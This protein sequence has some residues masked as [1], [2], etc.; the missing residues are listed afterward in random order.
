MAPHGAK[1]PYDTTSKAL[2]DKRENSD[3]F[4]LLNGD[5]KFTYHE[6][7]AYVPDG[8]YKVA[9]DDESWDTIPVPSCW[10]MHGY[11]R[12]V[13]TNV[14]YQIPV[15]APNVPSEN[16]VGCYRRTFAVDAGWKTRRTVLHF[17]GVSTAFTVYIN[18]EEVG[19]SEGTH[20]PSEFDITDYLVDGDNVMAVEVYK[21]ASSTYLED[22]D[23]WR[24]HGIF[25]E[26][27]LYS[28]AKSYISD[29]K[30]DGQ[31]VNDFVDGQVT[32]DTKIVNTNNE[33]LTV[34]YTLYDADQKV[35]G[36]VTGTTEGD[37]L[38]VKM[39][40][41]KANPWTAETPYL[42]QVVF[43]MTDAAGQV[44]DI[45]ARKFG[46]ITVE[47]TKTQLL[48][49]GVSVILKGVNRHDTNPD[50]GY[51]VTREDMLL[52][53]KVMKE[54]NINIVRT[55]HYPND[56]YWYEICDEYGMYVMDEADLE[57]HGF[58][59]N[60]GL[61]RNGIGQP[62]GVNDDAQWTESFIDRGVRMVERDKNHPSIISWSLGNES[63]YGRNHREMAKA[64]RAI[65]DRPIHYES[66]GHMSGVDM[67]STMYPKLTEIIEEGRRSDV[68]RPYFICEFS[69]SMGN[70]MGNLQE[71]WDAIYAHERLIGGCVWEWADHGIR[72][73]N[74]DG[75]EYFAYGGDFGDYPNDMKFCIDGMVYPDRK[76][77]T[78]LTEFKQVIAPVKVYDVNKQG[79]ILIE[80]RY[81]FKTLDHLDVTYDLLNDGEVVYTGVLEGVATKAQTKEAFEVPMPEG[82]N[83]GSEVFLNLHFTEKE[84]G[85]LLGYKNVI[86]T[87]QILLNLDSREEVVIIDEPIVG[88]SKAL[89]VSESGAFVKVTGESFQLT[90]DTAYG[91]ISSYVSGDVNLVAEGL[92]E[93]FWRAP[94]DNDERGWLVERIARQASGEM[95]VMTF[96]GVMLKTLRYVSQKKR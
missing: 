41:P 74:E 22:Q 61:E 95:W 20:V 90:F 7:P 42:Y 82:I 91:K 27:Y 36:E 23:Y 26:V 84:A 86:Y 6:H 73:T 51:A 53:L 12:A 75:E 58:I 76:P 43:E 37:A 55:S 3:Y 19:Y 70:S 79:K 88:V 57:T 44:I 54:H 40:L 8:Y 21:W 5:W 63:G 59:R 66:A 17:A 78:G 24:L 28:S 11:D 1:Y 14:A 65:D 49:N 34:K 35:V 72:T 18:G 67:T 47:M 2:E 87:N 10:Q 80:N 71:I 48:I 31:M 69:H 32:I 92:V 45:R 93:N 89:E 46:F 64:I 16:P 62:V 83:L 52:D 60:A 96:Y 77:H 9:Y 33:A 13:Y 56:S 94:T 30:V 85:S 81:D 38:S 29:Y 25:R 68:D 4:K 15:D 50:R 39:A